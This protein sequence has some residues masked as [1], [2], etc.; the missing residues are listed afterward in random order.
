MLAPQKFAE[1]FAQN[2]RIIKMQNAAFEAMTLEDLNV[3]RDE[4]TLG[5]RVLELYFH[6]TYHTGQ[7]EI[8]RQLAGVDD[9][10]I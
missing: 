4:R 9:K 6:E 1:M 3:L 2:L 10:V 5:E 7:T 8:L